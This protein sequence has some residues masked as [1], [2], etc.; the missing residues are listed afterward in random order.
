MEIQYK[1][2]VF[3][4][5]SSILIWV[6]LGVGTVM[7]GAFKDEALKNVLGFVEDEYPLAIMPLG[8][9]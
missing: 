4:I 9:I 2:I 8:K 5:A 3:I 1:I 6:S 7:I